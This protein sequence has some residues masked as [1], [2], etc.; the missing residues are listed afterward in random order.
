MIALSAHALQSEIDAYVAEGFD[1]YVAKPVSAGK[2][3]SE[4]NRILIEEK[5]RTVAA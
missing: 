3:T 5:N 2:F 1:G 4:I